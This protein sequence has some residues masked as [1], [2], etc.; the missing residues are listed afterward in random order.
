MF[1]LNF[2]WANPTFCRTE[3]YIIEGDFALTVISCVFYAAVSVSDSQK[4]DNFWVMDHVLIGPF[5][6]SAISQ[7]LWA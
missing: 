5:D 4:G 3:S 7:Y 2:D 6:I 1:E